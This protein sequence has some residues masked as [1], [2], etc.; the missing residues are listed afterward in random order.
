MV[1]ISITFF[2][3]PKDDPDTRT[4]ESEGTPSENRGDRKTPLD[5]F[6]SW[7][8]KEQF[9][10]AIGWCIIT[11]ELLLF[12]KSLTWW[13]T[14]QHPKLLAGIVL[15]AFLGGVVLKKN[16]EKLFRRQWYVG[17]VIF[18]VGVTGAILEDH[19]KHEALTLDQAVLGGEQRQAAKEMLGNVK[20]Y[21]PS[22]PKEIVLPKISFGSSPAKTKAPEVKV[23]E[24]T[25]SIVPG[26]ATEIALRPGVRNDIVYVG[27]ARFMD[28]NGNTLY[29]GPASPSMMDGMVLARFWVESLDSAKQITLVTPG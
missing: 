21:V 17:L 3:N 16:W 23:R 12:M 11:I 20:E 19:N 29:Q 18:L 15:L 25:Y 1:T 2:L 22:M 7:Y 4:D 14:G 27:S 26:Y 8:A 10:A 13:F 6:K 5:K 24:Q 28:R 9:R